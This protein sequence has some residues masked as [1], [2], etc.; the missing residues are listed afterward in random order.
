MGIEPTL[1]AWEAQVLPLNYTRSLS[2]NFSLASLPLLCRSLATG[3]TIRG[4]S[5]ATRE[6]ML[7]AN[8]CS[9]IELHPHAARKIR[10]QSITLC[11]VSVERQ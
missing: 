2:E 3:P 6:A 5:F 7:R 10:I 4:R 1:C 8:R 11:R 9:P